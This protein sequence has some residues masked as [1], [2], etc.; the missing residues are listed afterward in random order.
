MDKYV[1]STWTAEAAHILPTYL[2]TALLFVSVFHSTHSLG[3]GYPCHFK[4]NNDFCLVKVPLCLYKVPC[5]LLN[6]P[7]CLHG[8]P[9]CLH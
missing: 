4:D 1:E 7:N 6:V 2:S 9:A 8:V 3:D 5:C